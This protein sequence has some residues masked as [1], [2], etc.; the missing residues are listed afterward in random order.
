MKPQE[1]NNESLGQLAISVIAKGGVAE[2]SLVVGVAGKNGRAALGMATYSH[3]KPNEL[4][5]DSKKR[6]LLRRRL[7]DGKEKDSNWRRIWK[8]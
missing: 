6:L 8:E 4:T 3:S 7:V 2:C 1:L 5:C